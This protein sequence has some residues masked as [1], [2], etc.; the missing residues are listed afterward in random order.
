LWLSEI[1]VGAGEN[2]VSTTGFALDWSHLTDINPLVK[3]SHAEIESVF[4]RSSHVTL[5]RYVKTWSSQVS[6]VVS[7]LATETF[8]VYF[9]GLSRLS[10]TNDVAKLPLL[11]KQKNLQ[12]NL[13]TYKTLKVKLCLYTGFVVHSVRQCSGA[14]PAVY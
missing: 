6:I 7:R 11:W 3:L 14:R 2:Y 4:V 8:E 1:I 13:S 10:S 5:T 9:E 12:E